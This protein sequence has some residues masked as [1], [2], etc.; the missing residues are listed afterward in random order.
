MPIP[1]LLLE[2]EEEPLST[3]I[4]SWEGVMLCLSQLLKAKE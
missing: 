4:I 3:R 1:T 2:E